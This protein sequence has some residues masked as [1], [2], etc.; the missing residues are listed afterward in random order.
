MT[1]APA[2]VSDRII[3]RKHNDSNFF[4]VASYVIGKAIGLMP[5]VSNMNRARMHKFSIPQQFSQSLLWM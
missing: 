2:Q 5:Q 4:G 3:Y 1:S